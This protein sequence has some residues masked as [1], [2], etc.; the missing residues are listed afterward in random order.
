VVNLPSTNNV[1]LDFVC[2]VGEVKSELC[3]WRRGQAF[4]VN[5]LAHQGHIKN[6]KAIFWHKNAYKKLEIF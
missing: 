4:P 1:Y 5:L 6:N 3:M 2:F